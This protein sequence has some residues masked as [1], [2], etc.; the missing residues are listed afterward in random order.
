[1]FGTLPDL[2]LT[3]NTK[4]I[5]I[6][7]ITYWILVFWQN[8]WLKLTK[9]IQLKGIKNTSKELFFNF[10]KRNFFRKN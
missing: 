4:N 6:G 1:M 8:L 7:K 5:P 9:L 3:R 2:N 10:I